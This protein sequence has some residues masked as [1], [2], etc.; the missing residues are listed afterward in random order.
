MSE[1]TKVLLDEH[2][3]AFIT[4]KAK[5]SSPMKGLEPGMILYAV[6][7][8]VALN[9]RVACWN[10]LTSD[11]KRLGRLLAS[12]IAFNGRPGYAW[13]PSGKSASPTRDTL[14]VLP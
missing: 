4:A 8:C 6:Q 12:K 2:P 10:V 9:R 3:A 1:P 14:N 7:T 13:V 11:R 5:V